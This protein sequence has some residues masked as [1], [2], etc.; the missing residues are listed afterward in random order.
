[1]M[2][3]NTD[4]NRSQLQMFCTDELVPQDHLLRLIDS[5]VYSFRRSALYICGSMGNVI[6]V[7]LL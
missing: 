3:Q 4:K 6:V 7:R 2:T 1:M 5:Y